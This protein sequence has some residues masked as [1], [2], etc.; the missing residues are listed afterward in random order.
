MKR[1]IALFLILVLAGVGWYFWNTYHQVPEEAWNHEYSID[2]ADL[3][4]YSGAP[5]V[6]VNEGRPAFAKAQTTEFNQTF[7]ELD[8]LGRCG[9]AEACLDRT[10][11]PEGERGEIDTVKPSGWQVARYDFIDNDGFLYNRCHIIGWQLTGVDSEERNLITGTRYM[12]VEGMLP[13]ENKVAHYLRRTENHVL[14]RVTPVFEGKELLC[15]GVQIE[16]QSVEDDGEGVSFNVYCFNVQPGVDIDY[17]TG[18]NH[19]AQ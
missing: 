16:A 5:S 13:Y 11:M 8:G 19:L 4:E 10:H 14:Y 15:R 17:M 2:L 3:P 9:P 6:S 12:N 7:S 18:D 1:T